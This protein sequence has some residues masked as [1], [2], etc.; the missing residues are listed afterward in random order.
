MLGALNDADRFNVIRFSSD[1]TNFR[2]SVVPATAE[3][4]AAARQFVEEFKAVGGTGIDD[5]LQAGLSSL[6]KPEDRRGR[7][8]FLIFMTDGLPTVG[9]TD[10]DRILSNAQKAA[11]GDLRLFSFGV[12]ADVN[13]LLLDR[14][15][16]DN[17]GTADYVSQNEDLETKIGAFYA[18]IADPVLSNVKVAVDGAQLTEVYPSKIPDLFAGTQ[19]LLLGR[20]KGQGKVSVNLTG[21]LNGKPQSYTY[22]LTLPEREL[23]NEFI[24]K[25]W[26][27]RR[28]GFLLEELRLKGENKELKDEVIRLSKEHGIVTP[29]TAYLVEEP[30]L[31]PPGVAFRLEQRERLDRLGAQP[32]LG[33]FGGGGV[34]GGLGGGLGGGRPAAPGPRG[35]AG[36]RGAS[37]A[38]GAV[39]SPPQQGQVAGKPAD[40]KAADRYYVLQE[41]RRQE[42]EGF[43]RSTGLSAVEAS[44]RV[45]QLK[46]QD[47]AETDLE[48]RR[49]VQ[50]RAFRRANQAW[51]E[52]EVKREGAKDRTVAVKYGTDAYFKLL[53]RAEWAKFLSLGKEVTFRTGKT[54]LVHVGPAG[55][56]HLT[57]AE[58]TQLTR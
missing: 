2:P 37:P 1:T 31:A 46:D 9:I 29:Y 6:P 44:R 22:D 32:G 42:A 17:R 14:L 38:G 54:T 56:D 25:L 4:R 55:K 40:N 33:G 50:G 43:S 5:A 12:G 3:N 7:A 19:L 53:S 35:P 28:I 21:E 8:P 49:V 27:G 26:A 57:N 48:L 13:T 24:P 15:A 30:N 52:D 45:Q 23:G 11:A 41:Q 36:P 34:G 16:R 18:K 47:K 51:I 58:L 20:Y 39:Q 10:V